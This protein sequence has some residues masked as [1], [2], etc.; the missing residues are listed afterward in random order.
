MNAI[1]DT[2]CRTN[3]S[4]D[5]TPVFKTLLIICYVDTNQ[6]YQNTVFQAL[7]I[8]NMRWTYS[9]RNSVISLNPT[10]SESNNVSDF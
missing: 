1:L 6:R 10:V 2:I 8:Q 5:V 4:V 3:T 7:V 9:K